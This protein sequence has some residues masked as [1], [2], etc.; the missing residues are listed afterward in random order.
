VVDVYVG[1]EGVLTGSA[2]LTREAQDKVE[3]LAHRQKIESRKRELEH[4]RKALE[5]QINVLKAAFE[6]E[7]KELETII[8]QE[9]K[10]EKTL[11]EERQDIEKARQADSL[12]ELVRSGK[13]RRRLK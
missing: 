12:I 6:S 7:A 1:P 5:E 9:E 3:A 2:R 10:R 13:E 4:K 11:V 8:S